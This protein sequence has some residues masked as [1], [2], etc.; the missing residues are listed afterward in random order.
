MSA[1]PTHHQPGC[2]AWCCSVANVCKCCNRVTAPWTGNTPLYVG[3]IPTTPNSS[4]LPEL[5]FYPGSLAF[6]PKSTV[7][8]GHHMSWCP[9][10]TYLD[11]R[12]VPHLGKEME[13]RSI[14]SSVPEREV[15]QF[16]GIH[17]VGTL[18][19]TISASEKTLHIHIRFWKLRWIF[20]AGGQENAQLARGMV[21]KYM[22][23]ILSAAIE[24]LKK[25]QQQQQQQQ[26]QQPTTNSQQPTAN[27]Q[28]AN[29]QQPTAKSQQPTTNNQ[30]PNKP[31]TTTTTTNKQK[32]KTTTATAT[33]T[34]TTTNNKQQTTNNQQPTTNNQ[35]PTTNNQQTT[36]NNNNNIKFDSGLCQKKM[37]I[38]KSED[39]C[40]QFLS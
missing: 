24:P 35:Q 40:L 33:A 28:T 29:S 19:R 5:F 1:F 13:T 36:N 18:C 21:D 27:S 23:R 31:T 15:T 30:Q 9:Q 8:R 3:V 32:T 37:D 17:L 7:F 10:P 4:H 12:L 22:M 2:G 6:E 11:G 26:K 25:Q 38:L 34:T 20:S 14:G 39:I 16:L